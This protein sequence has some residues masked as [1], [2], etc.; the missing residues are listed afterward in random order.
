[1]GAKQHK[2]HL[3]YESTHISIHEWLQAS[4]VLEK[5]PLLVVICYYQSF[6][7]KDCQRL[8][9]FFT[10]TEMKLIDSNADL[11]QSKKTSSHNHKDLIPGAFVNVVSQTELLYRCGFRQNV[12]ASVSVRREFSH[13]HYMPQWSR[14]AAGLSSDQCC[15]LSSHKHTPLC[16]YTPSSSPRAHSLMLSLK[17]THT[18]TFTQTPAVKM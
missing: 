4:P 8:P 2:R 16:T 10:W 12:C 6:W 3:Q 9:P 13:N 1:M 17:H 14:K 18:H 5:V 7:K 15:E 11:R